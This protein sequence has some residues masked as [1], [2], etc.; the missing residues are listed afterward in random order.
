MDECRTAQHV[1]PEICA[2]PVL[3][4]TKPE[5]ER[6]HQTQQPQQCNETYIHYQSAGDRGSITT[7][8]HDVFRILCRQ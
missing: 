3:M 6:L 4:D 7:H 5:L 2:V 8:G 1:K